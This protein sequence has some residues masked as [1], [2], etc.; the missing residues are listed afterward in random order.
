MSL[1]YGLIEF[2]N[3]DNT[4][5]ALNGYFSPEGNIYPSISV[6]YEWSHVN[7]KASSSKNSKHFLIGLM[8]DEVR[9]GTF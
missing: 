1:T 3:G 6:G 7:S 9:L 8:F 5:K 4:H 2:G